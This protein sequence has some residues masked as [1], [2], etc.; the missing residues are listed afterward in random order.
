MDTKTVK[1]VAMLAR[2]EF[3]DE[4]VERLAIELE[5]ILNHFG[6]LDEVEGLEDYSLNP[7][8][9]IDILREDMAH[10]DIPVE[11]LMKD[12]DTYEGYVRGPR[13]S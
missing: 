1:K 10:I 9:V 6:L 13:L 8:E 12:M 11:E 3:S 4:E 5:T 2:L 7:I